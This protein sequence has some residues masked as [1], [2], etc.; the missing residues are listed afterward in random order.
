MQQIIYHCFISSHSL[1]Q[2]PT[3]IGLNEIFVGANSFIGGIL[4]YSW[5]LLMHSFLSLHVFFP[6]LWRYPGS[7]YNLILTQLHN[8][9]PHNHITSFKVVLKEKSYYSLV[10]TSL[11]V[12]LPLSAQTRLTFFSKCL[13][14]HGH[15]QSDKGIDGGLNTFIL[16][17]VMTACIPSK[18][19]SCKHFH[20]WNVVI[21]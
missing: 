2:F 11:S 13:F 19:R 1:K 18:V 17:Y 6:P 4:L 10:E 14:L 3:R 9:T 20:D 16:C 21:Q 5:P 7:A 8:T 15:I 12:Q